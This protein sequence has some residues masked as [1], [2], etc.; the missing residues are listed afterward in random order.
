[1]PHAQGLGHE[2]LEAVRL[3]EALRAGR[4][5]PDGLQRRVRTGFTGNPSPAPPG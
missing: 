3:N 5:P 1:M 2:A 4:L